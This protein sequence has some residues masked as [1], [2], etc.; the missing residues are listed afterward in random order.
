MTFK[1]QDIRVPVEHVARKLNRVK[2]GRK[3]NTAG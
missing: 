1:G 2:G 3:R